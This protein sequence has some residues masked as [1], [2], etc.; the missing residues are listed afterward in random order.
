MSNRNLQSPVC[1]SWTVEY[2]GANFRDEACYDMA[3]QAAEQL[4][5]EGLVS[6]T[7]LVDMVKRA[8]ASLLRLPAE[9]GVGLEFDER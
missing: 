7:E 8:N 9:A 4:R 6:N 1:R 3:I 2:L 5:A